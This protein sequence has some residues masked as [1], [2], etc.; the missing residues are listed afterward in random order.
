[1]EF[2]VKK[3]KV[4]HVGH[5]NQRYQYTMGGEVLEVT[6]EER[7]I[8]VNMTSSLK[9]SQQCRKAAR[10]AQTVLSQLARAFHFRDRHVFLRLYIQYVRPHLEYAV[11]AW[12]PWYESDKECLEKVQRRAVKM[13]S[14][15]KAT[16]YEDKLKELGITTLEERRRYL[17]MIQTYKVLT[18]KDNVD[19]ATWFD[20]AS[21]G[22]RATRQAADPLNIRPKAARLEVRRQFFSQRVVEDWN[23][24]PEQVKSA[25]SVTGFKNGLKKHLQGMMG[26]VQ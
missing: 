13:I 4:M 7:D 3:C 21:T 8:G 20:M 22:L 26:P 2:N 23:G 6:E 18:G 1:M 9:P 17:D 16:S 24:V 5:N 15:L 12:A 25:V 14:G 19:R 10:T 11:A